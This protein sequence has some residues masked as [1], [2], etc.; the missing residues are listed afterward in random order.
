M[1]RV[2]KLYITKSLK[3]CDLIAVRNVVKKLSTTGKLES[4]ILEGVQNL[5][6]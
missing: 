4:R 6:N 5:R 2:I 3:S 1:Q